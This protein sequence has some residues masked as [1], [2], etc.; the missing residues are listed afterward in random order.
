MLLIQSEHDGVIEYD[1]GR[2]LYERA[3]E[4]GNTCDFYPNVS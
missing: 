2:K 3:K 1:C 4:L